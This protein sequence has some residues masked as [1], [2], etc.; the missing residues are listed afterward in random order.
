M[1]LID[2]RMSQAELNSLINMADVDKNGK[3]DYEGM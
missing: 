2:E 3:I 1:E